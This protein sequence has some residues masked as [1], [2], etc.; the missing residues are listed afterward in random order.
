[1]EEWKKLDLSFNGICSG[2]LGS[3]D[4]QI[5]I[6]KDFIK[7]FKTDDTIVVCGPG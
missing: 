3:A 5:S 7:E 2:F 1:M 4:R 6:V